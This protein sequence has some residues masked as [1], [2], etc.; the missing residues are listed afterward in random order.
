MTVGIVSESVRRRLM[1][2]LF[3][4]QSVMSAAQ[5]ASFAILPLAAVHLT[6]SEA[7]AGVPTT[8]TLV[9]RALIAFPIGWLMDRMGRR[10]GITLGLVPAVIG[11]AIA[12]AA[13]ITGSFVWFCVGALLTGMGRGTAEQSRYAAADIETAQR[14]AK[15]IGAIVFASTIGAV[16]GPLLLP[17][18]EQMADERGVVGLAGPFVLTAALSLSSLLIIFTFLRPDPQEISQRRARTEPIGALT[19]RSQREIFHEPIVRLAVS[20]LVIS[21]L[22][23]TLIMVITPLHMAHAHHSTQAIS[24]VVMAH[25]LGMFGLSSVTGWLVVRV[26]K[27]PVILMGALV[28]AVSALLAPISNSVW[29]LAFAL[30]LLGLGWNLGF[31][32]GSAL[33]AGALT[34]GEKGKTQGVSETFVAIA[35]AAGSLAT[36]IAFQWG[37]LIAVSMIGLALSLALTAW[38]FWSRRGEVVPFAAGD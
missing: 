29:M 27:L 9:G 23:M 19:I 18:A 10:L 4:S 35:A 38:L 14:A 22:V 37:G 34:M 1:A 36:G 6:G 21:Q 20:T 33:L 5:G 31:V 11:A 2:T 28:L 24:W 7:L 3:A 32:A 13:L 17:P 16:F 30:F 8:I 25:T 15:A 12:A 26:G